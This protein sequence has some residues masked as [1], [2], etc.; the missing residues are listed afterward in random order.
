MTT[1]SIVEPGFGEVV[2][3]DPVDVELTIPGSAAEWRIPG[4][5]PATPFDSTYG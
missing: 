2:V 3:D 1:T 4:N 5:P